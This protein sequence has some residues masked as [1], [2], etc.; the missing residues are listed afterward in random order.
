MGTSQRYTQKGESVKV[1]GVMFG[2]SQRETL[3]SIHLR[4]A[5]P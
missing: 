2:T 5:Q 3:S 1:T 4:T